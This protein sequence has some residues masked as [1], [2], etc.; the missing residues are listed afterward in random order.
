MKKDICYVVCAGENHGID[1][2][3]QPGDYVIAADGGFSYLEQENIAADLIIGDFDTLRSNPNHSNI[4]TLNREKDETDTIAA[5]HY[6]IE[7]GY[8]L[9]HIYC[10]TGGRIEHTIAN[11]QLLAF[12]SKNKMQGFLF[13]KGSIITSLS[14]DLLSFLPNKIPLQFLR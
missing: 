10:G 7:K 6:G 2:T 1:F 12:L 8:T 4:I 13:D 11:I 5:V 14:Q 9:F 3:V